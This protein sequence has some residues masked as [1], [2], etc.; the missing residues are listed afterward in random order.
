MGKRFGSTF[1][2][3]TASVLLSCAS[4]HAIEQVKFSGASP[5]STAY[6]GET[7]QRAQ[8]KLTAA[9]SAATFRAAFGDV[10]S[11]LACSHYNVP[12]NSANYYAF[13]KILQYKMNLY[14]L[15]VSSV[16]IDADDAVVDYEPA[17][18]PVRK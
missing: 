15:A 12:M 6:C 1:L 14:G 5:A 17:K 11:V 18:S 4:A 8:A 13:M 2:L 10:S 9:N 7:L 16:Q 3:T